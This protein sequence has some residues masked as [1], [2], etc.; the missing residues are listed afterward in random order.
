MTRRLHIYIF[1]GLWGL[2][3]LI[4]PCLAGARTWPYLQ[5]LALLGEA[6]P[7]LGAFLSR[8]QQGGV[9]AKFRDHVILEAQDIQRRGMPAEPYLLKANEGLAKRV[10]VTQMSSALKRTRGQTVEAARWVDQEIVRG[11]GV[12]SPRD[13]LET[14][15]VYQSVLA[16]GGTPRLWPDP[17]GMTLQELRK[18]VWVMPQPLPHPEPAV[19]KPQKQAAPVVKSSKNQ[20]EKHDKIHQDLSKNS[21]H[22]LKPLKPAKASGKGKG[23][24]K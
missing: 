23:K 21:K 16:T 24:S 11:A 2:L 17:K 14:I 18:Q 10:G 12:T 1:W 6:S 5:S 19:A 20:K 9:E 15:Q 4:R 22:S 8:A 7:A 3:V 13:R